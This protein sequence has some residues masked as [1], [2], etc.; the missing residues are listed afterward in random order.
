MNNNQLVQCYMCVFFKHFHPPL[1]ERGPGDEHIMTIGRFMSHAIGCIQLHDDHTLT[2]YLHTYR[3]P[4]KNLHDKSATYPVS[5][6]A[7]TR[8]FKRSAKLLLGEYFPFL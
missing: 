8:C 7:L 5:A 6:P 4:S 3:S 2:I 1:H